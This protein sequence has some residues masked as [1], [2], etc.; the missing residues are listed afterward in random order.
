MARVLKFSSA[1]LKRC[2][3]REFW[4]MCELGEFFI[5]FLYEQS[6]CSVSFLPWNIE[7]LIML[8]E[9]LVENMALLTAWTRLLTQC[10]YQ[11]ASE[12][13]CKLSWSVD[14]L[15]FLLGDWD[16]KYHRES[17][18]NILILIVCLGIDKNERRR[19]FVHFIH[20]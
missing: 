11:D 19:S 8:I 17:C 9:N 14:Q 7:K 2:I 3:S 1:I 10:L 4:S 12:F 5:V 20:F 13:F 18:W 15:S 6:N 16:W